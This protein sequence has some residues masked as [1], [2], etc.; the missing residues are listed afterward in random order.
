LR[1]GAQSRKPGT[2]TGRAKDGAL[3]TQAEAGTYSS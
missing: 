3:Q 2:G 1:L